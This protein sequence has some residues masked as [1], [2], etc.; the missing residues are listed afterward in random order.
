MSQRRSKP[1]AIV[2]AREI[3]AKPA[4]RSRAARNPI[5]PSGAAGTQ[6]ATGRQG[7]LQWAAFMAGAHDADLGFGAY[8]AAVEPSSA[9]MIEYTWTPSRRV[10]PKAL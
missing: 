4:V 9:G 8:F 3:P 10:A 1:V 6:S 7:Y 2:T 5:R